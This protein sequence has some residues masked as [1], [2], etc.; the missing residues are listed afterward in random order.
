[1]SLKCG[2]TEKMNKEQ[3]TVT[4]TTIT[5]KFDLNKFLT[6]LQKTSE[7][8]TKIK[9]KEKV[10]ILLP[11]ETDHLFDNNNNDDDF[12][13]NEQILTTILKSQLDISSSTNKAET[14]YNTSNF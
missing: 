12:S 11:V 7:L 4:V 8:S 2:E 5:Q 3:K 9:E 14:K 6:T 13:R 1:M 10:S